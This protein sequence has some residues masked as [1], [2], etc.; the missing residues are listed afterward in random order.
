[1]SFRSIPIWLFCFVIAASAIVS[2]H[3]QALD[4]NCAVFEQVTDIG[5]DDDCCF[6]TSPDMAD[7]HT[8][9]LVT[10]TCSNVLT[11]FYAPIDSVNSIVG[12]PMVA[13]GV[14]QGRPS[15]GSLAELPPRPPQI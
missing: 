8:A 2:M 12:L 11:G 15:T 5:A 7:C 4:A 6:D 14:E 10:V 3:V 13:F 1:M 9:C